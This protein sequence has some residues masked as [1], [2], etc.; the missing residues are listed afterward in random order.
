M[1]AITVCV[2]YADI[3]KWTLPANYHQFDK[4][5]VVTEERDEDTISLCKFYD[6]EYVLAPGNK[7]EKINAGIRHLRP[8]GWIVQMDADIWLPPQTINIIRRLDLDETALYGI[9]RCMCTD[10]DEFVRFLD[11]KSQPYA[12]KFF[13]VPPFDISP[14]VCQHY[15]KG[16]IPIGYF[17]L[18]HPLGSSRFTY[19]TIHDYDGIYARTDVQHAVTFQRR[20]L[21]PEVLCVHLE[22]GHNTMGANW[23]GR[24]TPTF[25]PFAGVTQNDQK[26][27]L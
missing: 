25:G 10:Y 13:T 19:P 26:I 8:G 14:R 21:I 2:D 24:T 23:N 11:G 18:W 16:Y 1:Q 17:Q 5:V 4:M 6:V 12:E 15:G 7:G 3:L 9:D 22:Q 20:H 27:T